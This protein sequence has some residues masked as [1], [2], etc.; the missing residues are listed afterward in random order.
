MAI[1][2][3]EGEKVVN[4]STGEA[5]V[6]RA[7]DPVVTNV[8]TPVDF[9]AQFPT[10]LDPT[11]ILDMCEEVTLLQAIPE[12]RTGLKTELWREMTSLEFVSGSNY[13]PFVDGECPEEYR[14]DGGN[15]SVDLKNL[16]AKKSLTISDIMHSAAVG[17]R[18]GAGSPGAGIGDGR[19]R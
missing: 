18:R 15:E 8:G 10:P 14:H 11:E 9:A 2:P 6:A 16:G 17:C 19:R 1:N 13:I 12:K 4:P 5:F 7:T 3:L